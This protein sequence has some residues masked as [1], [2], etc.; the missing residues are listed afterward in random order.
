MLIC[1]SIPSSLKYDYYQL[2]IRQ[3]KNA[4]PDLININRKLLFLILFNI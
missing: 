2:K 4:Y 3:I 1:Y